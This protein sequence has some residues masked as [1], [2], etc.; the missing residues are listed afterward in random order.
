M[1]QRPR[2]RCLRTSKKSGATTPPVEGA[3]PAEARRGL[4][5][6]EPKLVAEIEFRGWTGGD[7]VRQASFKALREDKDPRDIVREVAVAPDASSPAAPTA[8]FACKAEG[9]S[10]EPRRPT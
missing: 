1:T 10:E 4:R 9:E 5:W 8:A 2:G 3:L 7:L 6:T